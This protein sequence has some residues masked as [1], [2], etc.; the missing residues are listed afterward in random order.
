[1][2]PEHSARK[3]AMK[4]KLFEQGFVGIGTPVRD[5]SSGQVKW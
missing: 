3:A 5:T 2:L 4:K 1:M